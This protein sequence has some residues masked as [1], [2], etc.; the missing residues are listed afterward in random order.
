MKPKWS[1][2]GYF[3]LFRSRWNPFNTGGTVRV[4]ILVPPS[5]IPAPQLLRPHSFRGG[6]RPARQLSR[7]SYANKKKS[8]HLRKLTNAALRGRC[9]TSLF[10]KPNSYIRGYM[11]STHVSTYVSTQCVLHIVYSTSYP[12]SATIPRPPY[13]FSSRCNPCRACYGLTH[14]QLLQE[15]HIGD[16]GANRIPGLSNNRVYFALQ[17]GFTD[18]GTTSPCMK[19]SKQAPSVQT[20][21]TW[22][23][24]LRLASFSSFL[25]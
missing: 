8:L 10:L 16:V 2:T 17:V 9:Q 20:C 24:G 21:R 22:I 5:F 13:L 3:N 11:C 25:P 4:G 23:A 12:C 14:L 7:F 1:G 19:K 6:D 18:S 15:L